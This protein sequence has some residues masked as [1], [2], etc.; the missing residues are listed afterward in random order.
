[1]A[2]ASGQAV[3]CF[4][5]LLIAFE[6]EILKENGTAYYYCYWVFMTVSLVLDVEQMKLST[7]A[8][9]DNEE[10]QKWKEIPFL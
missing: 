6:S 8:V 1:M 3:H 2:S 10:V 9:K 5:I 4:W 7:T